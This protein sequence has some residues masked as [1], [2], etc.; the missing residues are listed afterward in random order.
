MSTTSLCT[1]RKQYANVCVGKTSDGWMSGDHEGWDGAAWCV[2]VLAVYVRVC[3]RVCVR[4]RV[5]A[6]V[7][8]CVRACVCWLCVCGC[9]R[10]DVC[11][12]VCE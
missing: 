5:C 6:R 3:M 9:V 1:F 8:V 11:A 10:V 4:V 2:C 12:C 7:C